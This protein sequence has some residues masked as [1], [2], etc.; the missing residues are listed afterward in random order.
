MNKNSKSFWEWMFKYPTFDRRYTFSA[1]VGVLV[2]FLIWSIITFK[3]N[4]IQNTSDQLSFLNLLVQAATLILGL[5]AA[6]YALRQL[7]ETRFATLD[8]GAMQDLRDRHYKRA[9]LKWKEAFYVHQNTDVFLNLCE[10]MI[11]SANLQEFDENAHMLDTDKQLQLKIL[12]EDVDQLI[13]LYLKAVRH[14]LV[15]NQGEAEKL[16]GEVVNTIKLKGRLELS[17]NFLDLLGSEPYLK[18][19]TGDCKTIIDNLIAYLKNEMAE[20][21]REVFENGTY[22]QSPQTT[23][24]AV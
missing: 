9:I 19:T 23:I 21:R 11:L 2:L 22:N 15:K 3:T 7:I 24:P 20:D 14:L 16:I 18:L 6:Y 1:S 13:Y 17:W 10:T 12:Q 4:I 8:S 5:F